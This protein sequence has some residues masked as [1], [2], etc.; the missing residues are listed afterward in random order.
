MCI[1]APRGPLCKEHRHQL[2]RTLHELRLSMYELK[3][4]A[5]RKVRLGRRGGGARPAFAPTPMDLSAADL[6]DQVEDIIQDVAGDIGLWGGR[7]PQVLR[8]LTA[9]IGRLYDAPNS[10]RDYREL[11]DALRR[12]GERVSAPGER[13]VYGRCLNPMCKTVLSGPPDGLAATCPECGSTWTVKALTEARV[14]TLRGQTITCTPKAAGQW[15]EWKTGKRVTRNRVDMWLR[16]GRLPS[17]QR[18]DGP[19]RW[20]FDTGELLECLG[21]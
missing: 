9:R 21:A 11:A 8:K 18:T 17:A 12:V 15:L 20:T 2:A 14:D 7:A 5:D 6:Y 13:V 3:D 10:G 19:G 4:A 1:G 16:R